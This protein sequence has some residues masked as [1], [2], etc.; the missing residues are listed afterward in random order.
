MAITADE[1][2]ELGVVEDHEAP[3][4]EADDGFG[5]AMTQWVPDLSSRPPEMAS[6][7]ELKLLQ[8]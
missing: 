4:V 8:D 6:I 7:Y 5:G 3:D 2:D 1:A